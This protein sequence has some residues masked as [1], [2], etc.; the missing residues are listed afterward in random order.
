VTNNLAITT[1]LKISIS[2]TVLPTVVSWGGIDINSYE[3]WWMQDIDFPYELFYSDSL[4]FKLTYVYT[5][6]DPLDTSTLVNP[7]VP[8]KLY[9]FKYRGVNIHGAGSFSGETSLYASTLPEKTGRPS[10]SLT[11]TTLTV[12]WSYT[13][14][15]HA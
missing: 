5:K 1:D 7:I 12:T 15:D 10:T 11:N 14:N 13:P 6:T 3:I 9:K 4:P 8:G 2:W